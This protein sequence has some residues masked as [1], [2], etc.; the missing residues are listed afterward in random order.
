MMTAEELVQSI[1][2]DD[3]GSDITKLA[4]VTELFTSGKPKLMFDGEDIASEKEYE[5][6]GS[7]RP[8]VGDRVLLLGVS[9]TWV[10]L[11]KMGLATAQEISQIDNNLYVNGQLSSNSFHHRGAYLSFFNKYQNIPKQNI[12]P[13]TSGASNFTTEGAY[14]AINVIVNALRAYGLF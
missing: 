14:N 11:G 13:L 12:A 2:I 7:Y 5:S 9:G 8:K 1:E 3:G 10:I 4:T 6:L